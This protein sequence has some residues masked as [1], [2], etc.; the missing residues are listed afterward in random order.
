MPWTVE[1][2]HPVSGTVEGFTYSGQ[3]DADGLIHIAMPHGLE[4]KLNLVVDV[5]YA[6]RYAVPVGFDSAKADQPEGDTQFYYVSNKTKVI[7][8]WRGTAS[9][10]DGITDASFRPVESDICNIKSECTSLV[11]AGKVH[12]G[13]WEGYRVI[14]KLLRIRRQVKLNP[15]LN[16]GLSLP[17]EIFMKEYRTRQK[18]LHLFIH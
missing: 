17:K 5:P 10:T 7:V 8:A 12:T 14:D 16:I 3:S 15:S 9:L 4:L 1:S 6:D 11:P 13:F 18:K 2:A